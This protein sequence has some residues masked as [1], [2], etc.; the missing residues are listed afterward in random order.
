MTKFTQSQEK[1]I[2]LADKN[3]LVSAGAGSGKTTVMIARIIDLIVNKRIPISNFLVVTFTKASA[4]DMTNKLISGLEKCEP[5]DF[6]LQQIEEVGTSDVSNLHSFCARLLKTY[7]YVIGLDPSFVV[8]DELEMSAL[9]QRAMETLI[10]ECLNNADKEMIELADILNKNR[11]EDALEEVIVNLSKFLN[12]QINPEVWFNENLEKCY[13]TNLEK[14]ECA[15]IINKKAQNVFEY[16]LSQFS[17]IL[18]KINEKSDEKLYNYVENLVFIAGLISKNSS[19]K[20]N[21]ENL[22]NLPSFKTIPSKV[23]DDMV[24]TKLYVQELKNEFS[25]RIKALKEMWGE[26]DFEEIKAHLS[27]NKQRVVALKRL[28]DRYCEILSELKNQKGGLDFDDLEHF[29]L[30]LLEHEDIVSI[31]KDKYKYVFVDEYQDISPIQEQILSTISSNNNRFMVGDIKQSIYRFR[32]CEPEIFLNRY[33]DYNSDKNDNDEVVDLKENFRS[34]YKILDFCNFIFS[35]CYTKDFGGINYNPE[36]LLVCGTDKWENADDESAVSVYFNDTSALKTNENFKQDGEIQKLKVYSVLEHDEEYEKEKTIAE[37]EAKIVA[38]S[39]AKLYGQKIRNGSGVE[40]R[41]L[42]YSDFVVLMASRG[43]YLEEFSKTLKNLGIPVASDYSEDVFQDPDILA[44]LNLLKIINN[45]AD[46]Y[47][48]ISLMVSRLFNFSYNDL[49]KIKAENKNSKFFYETVKNAYTMQNL[50]ENLQNRLNYFMQTINKL[51]TLSKIISAKELIEEISEHF[52][53]EVLLCYGEDRNQ[54]LKRLIRFINTFSDISL[55]AYLENLKNSSVVCETV[56]EGDAVKVMTIHASKGLEF[57]VVYL[58]NCGKEFSKKSGMGDLLISKNLGVGLRYY[59]EDLRYKC[60]NFVRA[61]IKDTEAFKTKEENV[62]LFYVALTRAVNHLIV[63]AS[64]QHEELK[65][66]LPPQYAGGFVDWLSCVYFDKINGEN[67]LK[68]TAEINITSV[69]DFDNKTNESNYRQVIFANPNKE[70]VEAL[71]NIYNKSE[72]NAIYSYQAKSSVTKI[73]Q[74]ENAVVPVLFSEEE[75]FDANLGIIYHKILENA[76]FSEK[77]IEDIDKIIKKLQN[78]NLLSE[79]DAKMVNKLQILNVV[80]NKVI[81]DNY[82]NG[83]LKE[84]E[85]IMAYNPITKTCENNGEFMVVQGV[86]DLVLKTNGGLILI[87]YKL[88]NK[89]AQKLIET[90]SEQIRLY[91]L[92]L[93]ASYKEKVVKKYIC[94][95]TTGEFIEIS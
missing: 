83:A 90:Y 51:R 41:R 14:N 23:S 6:I 28:A 11:K 64:S 27:K 36:G 53:L 20:I 86:C 3:L 22:M 34:N 2:K 87:D 37:E 80:T 93:E 85:F 18:H 48:L 84:K 69:D 82:K 10:E 30:K 57:P 91:S 44:I 81:Q 31:L 59:D 13:N 38:S 77:T 33:N 1:A 24:S 60:E 88:T 45:F 39:I 8:L 68:G 63:V 79:N 52:N 19:V 25:A 94:K 66:N 7:F 75:G 74:E 54:K 15:Q 40:D 35:K 49:S 70:K 12:S 58:V 9:K 72:K 5:D 26:N 71:Q 50:E 92:A 95:L 47:T 61:V 17:A 89:N 43:T 56:P 67:K 32:L 21:F 46:D 55:S 16:Y 42:R 73:L 4:S 78:S 62:R 76:D 29:T 65:E